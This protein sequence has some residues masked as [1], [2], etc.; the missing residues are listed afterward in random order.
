MSGHK[1]RP[2][3]RNGPNALYL[4]DN[5]FRMLLAAATP[6]LKDADWIRGMAFSLTGGNRRA[7]ALREAGGRVYSK[8]RSAEDV[9]NT[10]R[11]ASNEKPG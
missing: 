8:L 3:A 5:E 10:R 1:P 9:M 11:L 6:A 4:G 7:Y 2:D